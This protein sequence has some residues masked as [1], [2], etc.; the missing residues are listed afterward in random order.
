MRSFWGSKKYSVKHD[1]LKSELMTD[2]ISGAQRHPV[3]FFNEYF[4]DGGGREHPVLGDLLVF[5]ADINE[6]WGKDNIRAGMGLNLVSEL[7]IGRLS[8]LS[9]SGSAQAQI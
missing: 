9:N 8:E 5:A 1:T 3:A 6:A 7:I 4:N 2:A